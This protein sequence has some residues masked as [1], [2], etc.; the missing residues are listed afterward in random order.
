MVPEAETV[1]PQTD[2]VYLEIKRLVT[3]AYA[4]GTPLKESTLA[5]ALGTSR[6]PVREAL[7]RLHAEGFLTRVPRRGYTVARI[8]LKQLQDTFEVRRLIEGEVAARAAR[9]ATPDEIDNLRKLAPYLFEIVDSSGYREAMERNLEFHLAIA[10]ASRNALMADLVQDCLIKMDRF[11]SLGVHLPQE[12]R[13]ATHHEHVALVEA[14]EKKDCEEARRIIQ[15][16]LDRTQGLMMEELLR[17][18]V[19]VT[20]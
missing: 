11:L 15:K 18:D 3:E 19:G 5:R 6:T 13:R 12:A 8:T 14:I 2:K 9:F 7:S 1:L 16:H 20:T 10:E 4:P 17:R